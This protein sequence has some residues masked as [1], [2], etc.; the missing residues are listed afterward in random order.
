MISACD[1]RVDVARL[2]RGVEQTAVEVAVI[3][4]GCAKG[5]VNVKTEHDMH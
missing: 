5:N 2:Q 4:D 3:T 1:E